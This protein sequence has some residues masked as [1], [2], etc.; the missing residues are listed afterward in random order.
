M[1]PSSWCT[2]LEFLSLLPS[3][4]WV[5]INVAVSFSGLTIGGIWINYAVLFMSGMGLVRL[6]E[7][8]CN[9]HIRLSISCN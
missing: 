1:D 7:S 4:D 9:H 8:G 2:G 5:K 6:Y 3:A